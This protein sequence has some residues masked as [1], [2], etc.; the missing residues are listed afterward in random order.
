MAISQKLMRKFW[1]FIL[2]RLVSSLEAFQ[3]SFRKNHM[4]ALIL[5]YKEMSGK[6]QNSGFRVEMAISQ[7]LVH[8]F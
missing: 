3:Q 2:N 4:I 7:K 5:K 8:R 1:G 6:V